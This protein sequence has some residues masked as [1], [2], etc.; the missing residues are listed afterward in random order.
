MSDDAYW[1]RP[2]EGS[3]PPPP[4]P[5]AP[6]SVPYSGAPRSTPPPRGWR[7]PTLENPRPPR[8]LP[9]QD[10]DRIDREEQA[11]TILTKGM[12]LFAGAVLVVLLLVLCGR[13]VF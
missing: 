7:P 1:R 9:G 4:E 8:R 10:R 3:E 11:A 13:V 12:G 6:A 5:S 2:P